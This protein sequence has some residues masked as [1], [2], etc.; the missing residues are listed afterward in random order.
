GERV[1]ALQLDVDQSLHVLQEALQQEKER[2]RQE[3]NQE[4]QSGKK[5]QS[6]NRLVPDT[7]ELKVLR[8]MDVDIVDD[9]DRLRLVHPEIVA[10][11]EIDPLVLEDIS[12]L[13]HRHERMTSLFQ[14]F[15]KRLGIPDPED[16]HQ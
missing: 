16:E 8:R 4:Q 15:R 12:R 3:Q 7:A 9:I 2:R 10:G 14:Q 1:Q 5:P 6:K 11:K 13:A